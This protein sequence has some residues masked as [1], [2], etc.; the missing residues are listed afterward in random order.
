MHPKKRQRAVVLLVEDD[1][2]DQE[3]TRRALEEDVIR[4]D[5]RI[6]EDGEEAIAYLLR[7]GRYAAPQ[8]APRPDLILLDLNLPKKDGRAVLQAVRADPTIDFIPI[9]VLTTS[10]QEADILRSYKLGCNSYITKP[11]DVQKFFATIRELGTYWLELVSLPRD[12]AG[13]AEA[14]E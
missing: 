4:V 12:A 3:I 6:V 2:G 14:F 9:V 8:A 10:D 13:S 11:I 1:P 7:Q 5:L